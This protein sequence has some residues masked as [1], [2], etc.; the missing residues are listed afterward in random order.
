MTYDD[1]I[2]YL[3]SR[4]NYERRGMPTTQDLRLDRM[5]LFLDWLG[6]PHRTY[7]VV[8]IAGTKG[9]GSTATMVAQLLQAAGGSVGLH[10]SPHVRAV[11]ER[12]CLN[13]RPIDRAAL[14]E[15]IA[16]VVPVVH[17]VDARLEPGQ[18][19]L[20]YF[21]ITTA[22][23]LVYF[24]RAA[25]N[26]AVVE[27]GMGGR[28]D[29][30]NIVEPAV[31]VITTISRD[32]T[33]QLGDTLAS[34]A[35]EKAGIIKSGRPV[36]SGVLPAEPA[37]VIRQTAERQGCTI[38]ELG[39]DF[40][41]TYAARGTHGGVVQIDTWRRSWPPISLSL[42]GEHQAANCAVAAGVLDVLAEQGLPFE[43]SQLAPA[44]M[45][46]VLP[47]RI[48][49][50]GRRPAIV[51]DAAHNLASVEA[52]VQTLRTTFPPTRDNGTRRIL[53]F[54]CSR[55]KDWQ[56]MLAVLADEFDTIIVTAYQNNPRVLP[57]SELAAFLGSR[58]TACVVAPRPVD[59]WQT[60]WQMT[61]MAASGAA[62]GTSDEAAPEALICICG[63]FFLVGELDPIV[64]D[65]VA[66]PG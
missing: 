29:A 32:H 46:L 48:E 19:P 26:W 43:P 17:A 8:H 16:G 11:E 41:Y 42:L 47:A 33:R 10:C 23:A 58:G 55:D 7:A 34:I 56:A 28:L 21:E 59:A 66:R 57:A 22:L 38:R 62:A 14:T 20:T 35:R 31:S 13:G 25:V 12:F 36:V 15:L 53:L 61:H 6:A 3:E 44:L 49:V 51:L 5:V 52:L 27:V 24:A 18:P 9:K 2:N 65:S 40:H 45:D 39:R 50:L 63:S 30:T 37:Q 60:A 64:R 4:I 54:S 1:A